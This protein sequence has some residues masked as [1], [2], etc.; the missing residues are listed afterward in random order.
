MAEGEREMEIPLCRYCDDLIEDDQDYVVI[1]EGNLV[2]AHC[3]RSRRRRE[4]PRGDHE[5]S[6]HD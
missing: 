6:A 2:H 3:F 1:S 5:Q 4:M